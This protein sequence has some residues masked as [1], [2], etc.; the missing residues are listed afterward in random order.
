MFFSLW[1]RNPASRN[2]IRGRDKAETYRLHNRHAG[3][4]SRRDPHA[5]QAG[6]GEAFTADVR[7]AWTAAYGLLAG[8]MIAAAREVQLA[9]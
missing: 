5:D 8:V 4:T 7:E 6:L 1:E 2:P 3:E 9:A